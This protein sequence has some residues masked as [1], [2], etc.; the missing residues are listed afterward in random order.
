MATKTGLIH[1]RHLIEHEGSI[2]MATFMKL[3][4]QDRSSG[5][6]IQNKPFGVNG[7][8]I[9][10]P[11]ISQLFGELI[12]IWCAYTWQQLGSPDDIKLIEL[13]PGTG[14]LMSDLLRA[15][16]NIKGF[17]KSISIHFVEISPILKASQQKILKK[18]PDISA[19]WHDNLI[20]IP[21][22]PSI[23][24]ANEFFDA[25]PINQYI[26]IYNEWH[27][28]IVTAFPGSEELCFASI[29]VHS[30]LNN[31]LNSEYPYARNR[32]NVEMCLPA[33]KV[34]QEICERFKQNPGAALI[35]DYGYDYEHK[36]RKHFSPTLQA[37]KNHRFHPILSDI[38]NADITSHVDFHA[39]REAVQARECNFFGTVSQRKL[40]LELGIEI[41]ADLLIKSGSNEQANEI[42]LAVDRL[43]SP[44]QMG[45]LF[46]VVAISSKT[47]DYL[48]G[49]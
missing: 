42:M 33:I 28:N 31:F 49:F 10:S 3:A 1:L 17:H 40:L 45:E 48:L 4:L 25:L 23:I 20:D 44:G 39:I 34:T 43:I 6:Y 35:V 14:I 15:T 2:D 38:G 47:V 13:G 7:D 41:R 30:K 8:F 21:Y 32:A 5:Y 19:N 22:G 26:K 24:I 27:E 11:E 16:K 29:P 46:K 9:T 18:F 36:I 37:V 12:G